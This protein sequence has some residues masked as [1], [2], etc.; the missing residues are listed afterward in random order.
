MSRFPMGH[1]YTPGLRVTRHAVIQK[2]RRLPLKGEVVVERGVEVRRDQVVA[3]T[4]LPGDVATMNIVNRLGISPQELAGYMLKKEGDQ[5]VEGEPLAETRPL[6]N[7]FKT[8]IESPVSGTV[9]SISPVTGQVI[10]R[11]APK[12]VEVLAYV[13]GVVDEVIAEEG[14]RIETRGAYIQGIFGVGGECWG[15]LH[16]AVE[17]AN[18]E[19]KTIGAEAA[20]KIV[21]VGSLIT[22][23]IVE[24]A[25]QTGAVGLIGGGMRDQDLR[26]LLGYDLGVAITGAEEIGLTVIVTEGFGGVAMAGKTFDI[27]RACS[28]MEASISG[29]TQI[30][31]G[32][33]RPEII[34]PS[35]VAG[36]EEHVGG[37][38]EGLQVGNV[39]R[40]IRM[41]YFGQI[42]RVSG[43]PA[44]LQEVESGAMVRVLEVE[45]DGG[46]QVVVPRANVELIEE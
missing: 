25:R 35:A 6:I 7:W 45:F 34:V 23:E 27:L 32:V 42:G 44:E 12:P 40:V 8:T 41:P 19:T 30:R 3:R 21:V 16:L 36:E 20:G 4:E 24:Q 28:G 2:E 10:L 38:S 43:L 26:D 46:E 31:A 13:D 1:A 17:D 15:A 14:V 9:E 11:K 5:V 29:A 37:D 18:A 22:L 39:L 33:L